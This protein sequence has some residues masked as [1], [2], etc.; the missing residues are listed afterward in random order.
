MMYQ[1]RIYTFF[2]LLDFEPCVHTCIFKIMDA[3]TLHF[4]RMS[5]GIH[6][7]WNSGLYNAC[8]SSTQDLTMHGHVVM[9]MVM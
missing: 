3:S 8:L 7:V 1:A 5:T 4:V 9:V 2:N 6:V